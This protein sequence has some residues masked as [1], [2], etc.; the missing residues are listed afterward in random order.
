MKIFGKYSI[1]NVTLSITRHKSISN[2]SYLYE[3]KI[4]AKIYSNV[5]LKQQADYIHVTVE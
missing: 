1:S 2:H 3:M 4:S 5:K